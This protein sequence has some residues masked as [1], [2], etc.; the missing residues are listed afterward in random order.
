MKRGIGCL[1]V[2]GQRFEV[3]DEIINLNLNSAFLC[4]HPESLFIPLAGRQ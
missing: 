4:N 1:V 3:G 2:W